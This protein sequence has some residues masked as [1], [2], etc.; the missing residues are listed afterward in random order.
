MTSS[1]VDRVADSDLLERTLELYRDL[2]VALR[3]RITLLSTGAGV[4]CM[5]TAVRKHHGTL[6]TVLAIEERL[7]KRSKAW[8]SAAGSELDLDA[9]RAEIAARLALW[10]E[11]R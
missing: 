4:D 9:A 2:T 1:A 5:D 7:G 11:R 10:A 3:A 8:A 6:Q